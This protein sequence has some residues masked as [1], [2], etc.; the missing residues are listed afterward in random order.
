MSGP[1]EVFICPACQKYLPVDETD[2]DK[3]VCRTAG[4]EREGKI[5]N[6]M[7]MCP[8]CKQCFSSKQ[9]VARHGAQ[10]HQ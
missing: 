9:A 2:E 4:C 7:Y 6:R 1:T 10:K 5:L 3:P 8:A